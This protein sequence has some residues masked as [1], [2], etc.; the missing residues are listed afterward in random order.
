M[1]VITAVSVTPPKLAEIVL[2]AVALTAFVFTVKVIKVF[3][4]GIVTEAGTV[5]DDRLLVSVTLIPP[6]GAM[7]ER[8]TVAVLVFPPATEVGLSVIRDNVGGLIVRVAVWLTVPSLAVNMPTFWTDTARVFAVNVAPV[9]PAKI[10]TDAGTTAE[11]MLLESLTSNP[12]TGAG[13]LIATD[14]LEDCPPSTA[15]GSRVAETSVGDSRVRVPVFETVPVLPVIDTAFSNATG[16]V[17]IVKVAAPSPEVIVT[18]L[19]TAAELLLLVRV[20]TRPLGP[21]FPFRTTVPTE[22]MPPGT[23]EGFMVTEAIV[24]GV[25]TNVADLDVLPLPAVTVAVV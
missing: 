22:M 10:V 21:A 9:L 15:I 25:S 20:T 4:A 17:E 3:P 13:L 18:D 16:S 19:G 23:V 14:P 1:T 5:T 24:A 8:L 11:G 6:V 12:P 7:E 2:F